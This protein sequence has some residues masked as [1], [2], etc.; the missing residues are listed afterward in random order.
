MSAVVRE[1][2]KLIPYS[3]AEE[4]PPPVIYI[5]VLVEE[6]FSSGRLIYIPFTVFHISTSYTQ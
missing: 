6:T 1:L 3:V 4:P 2:A 5:P